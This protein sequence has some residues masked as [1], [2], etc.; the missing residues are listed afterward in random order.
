MKDL[1]EKLKQ[2]FT[3]RLDKAN[4]ASDLETLR[5]DF[6][7]RK[8][9]L[10]QIFKQLTRLSVEEKQK[11]GPYLNQLKARWQKALANKHQKLT[12]T[13]PVADFNFPAFPVPTFGRLHPIEWMRQKTLEI[14]TPL[15]FIEVDGPHIENDWYNFE[16]LNIP[17]GHP[18]R[19][20]WDTLYV[21]L[22]DDKNSPL[23]LRTHTSNIQLRALQ[24]YKPP[25]KVMSFGRCF[26][27]EVLDPR[28]SHT[29]SQFEVLVVD[30][31]INM[32][33]LKWLSDY[34]LKQI[35]G[36]V[37]QSRFRPKY[38]PF[39]E[40]GVGVDA[41]C[42]F[43]A[44]QGCSVCSNSGWFEIAG[45]G[46]VHP[47]VLTNAGLDPDEYSGFAWGF[48]PD[49]MLMLMTGVDDIRQLYQGNLNFLKG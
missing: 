6:F 21:D 2:D 1:I 47:Q 22:K 9:K 19:D 49:R 26:R 36:E 27:H 45:A 3:N 8:G 31:N 44:G 28:H 40:P 14:F 12:Q 30:K 32:S 37:T 13:A 23:L 42:V 4:S 7:G 43:C 17:P 24:K 38:Y 20:L 48:G 46:M 39:V 35:L 29:F 33:H 5:V 10:N 18:A 11:W 16:G 34:F 41:K 15:G 25:L